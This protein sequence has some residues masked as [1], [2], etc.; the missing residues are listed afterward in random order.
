MEVIDN[1][2]I[3]IQIQRSDLKT[4]KNNINSFDSL[5]PNFNIRF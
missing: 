2:Q 5:I 1:L 4:L 3:K